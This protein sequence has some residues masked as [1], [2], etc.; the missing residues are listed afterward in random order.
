MGVKKEKGFILKS[1]V[2]QEADRVITVLN[3]SGQKVSLIAKGGNRHKS[4]FAGKLEPFSFANLNYFDSGKKGLKPL[5]EIE[6]T[7]N[8]QR[9]IKG[10]MKKFLTLSFLT[11]IADNFVFESEKNPKIFRLV[12]HVILSMKEGKDFKLS[13]S[14]FIF[15]MLKLSGLLK[16]DFPEDLSSCVEEILKNPLD[17]IDCQQNDAL[18]DFAVFLLKENSGKDFNSYAMLKGII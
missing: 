15:W 6:I 8:L 12:N 9:W 14:Y 1:F 10:D 5:N 16:E 18:F 13:L 11:E 7:D 2:I 3:E 4:K 17:K